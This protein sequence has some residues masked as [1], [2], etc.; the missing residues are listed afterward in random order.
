MNYFLKLSLISLILLY[1]DLSLAALTKQR[2]CE[3]IR[4]SEHTESWIKWGID[5]KRKM[6]EYHATAPS[7]ENMNKYINS[8][9]EQIG[10]FVDKEYENA[11]KADEKINSEHR[12]N[13]FPQFSIDQVYMR[14]WI[15]YEILRSKEQKSITQHKLSVYYYCM[16]TIKPLD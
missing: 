4:N 8:V 15:V 1:S 14:E 3:I 12:N 11:M 5:I 7:K 16:D 2:Y 13:N 9:F 10:K 6:D